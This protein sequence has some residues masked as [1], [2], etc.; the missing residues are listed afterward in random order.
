MQ[1]LDVTASDKN[2]QHRWPDGSS[3]K[4]S[5]WVEYRAKSTDGDHTVRVAFGHRETYGKRRRRVLVLIGDRLHAEFLGT[6]DFESTGD[7][8]SE[9][10]VPGENGER[11]CRYPDDVVP[12]RY[13]GLPVLGLPTR[14]AGSGVHN[15]WAVVANVSD[16]RVMCALAALRRTER[17]S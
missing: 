12:E 16:H 17:K 8:L 13:S 9:I 15:A 2:Y 1:L 6:D 14:I 4:Y 11:M 10:K 7:V 3:E 5:Q